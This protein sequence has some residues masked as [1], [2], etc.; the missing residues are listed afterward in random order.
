MDWSSA[1]R[2]STASPA[3]SL[4]ALMRWWPGIVSV[5]AARASSSANRDARPKRTQVVAAGVASTPSPASS[6]AS[7]GSIAVARSTTCESAWSRASISAS[8]AGP[9]HS[10]PQ[11]SGTVAERSSVVRASSWPASPDGVSVTV[12]ATPRTRDTM[13]VRSLTVVSRRG[14]RSLQGGLG[15]ATWTRSASPP[16]RSL[17]TARSGRYPSVPSTSRTVPP[18]VVSSTLA[19]ATSPRG[20]DAGQVNVSAAMAST[21]SVTSSTAAS[22]PSITA[23]RRSSVMSRVTLGT[24]SPRSPSNL[25]AIVGEGSTTARC[26]ARRSHSESPVA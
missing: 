21:R 22:G 2:K 18:R 4:P 1:S 15:S 5:T 3:A 7:S 24:P 26:S 19:L 16:A 17:S 12:A 13:G 10:T 23:P 8:T 20:R 6:A 14:R 11:P 25:A 9:C